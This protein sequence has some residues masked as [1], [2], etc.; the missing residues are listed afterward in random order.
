MRYFANRQANAYARTRANPYGLPLTS[1]NAVGDNEE[2]HRFI[3]G[4]TACV[5]L[6]NVLMGPIQIFHECLKHYACFGTIIMLMDVSSSENP[7]K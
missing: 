2:L 7:I 6:R 1:P 3:N 4:L 5:V